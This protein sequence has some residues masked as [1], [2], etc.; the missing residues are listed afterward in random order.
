MN[1]ISLIIDTTLLVL[2]V[3]GMTSRDLIAKHKRLRAFSTDDFDL[4][5]RLIADLQ[6]VFVTPNILTESSNWFGYIDEPA[7]TQ[8]FETFR[9]LILR[10]PEEYVESRTAAGAKDFLHLG[11]TDSASLEIASESRSL[12]TTDLDLY[13]SASKRG[14]SAVNFNHLR[15]GVTLV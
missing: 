7:R 13:L 4:L 10:I 12:L 5:C 8:I 3:V 1:Q 2:F 15:E 6:G 9:G 14:F 11:L